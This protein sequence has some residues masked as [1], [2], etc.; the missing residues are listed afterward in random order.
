MSNNAAWMTQIYVFF[1]F[2]RKK[3][4]MAVPFIDIPWALT[5]HGINL[6]KNKYI[7][8]SVNYFIK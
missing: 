4:K 8:Y 2:L 7:M 6:D 1:N 5:H 3:F